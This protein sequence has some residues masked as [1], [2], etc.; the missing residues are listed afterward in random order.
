M[1][2]AFDWINRNKPIEDL[3]NTIKADE[4]HIISKLLNVSFSM[5]CE[6]ALS[7]VFKTDTGAPQRDFTSTPEFTYY[8]T[9]TLDPAKSNYLLNYSYVEQIVRSNIPDHLIEHNY[10]MATQKDQIDIDMEYADDINKVT[11]NHSSIEMFKHHIS[12]VLEFKDLMVSKGK[13]K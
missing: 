8:L 6:N 3:R 4:L 12:E 2:K 11:S 9:K 1:S 7:E 10:C 13:T 5:T